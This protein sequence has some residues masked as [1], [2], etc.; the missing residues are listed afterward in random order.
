[1]AEVA[2][3]IGVFAS[4][5]VDD[6]FILL[7]FF[8]DPQFRS[9]QVVFG[10][11][12][13]IALLYAASVVAALAA[14]VLPAAYIGLLGFVPI[15]IG[16]KKIWHRDANG[17]DDPRSGGP[18]PG[19]RYGN[20]V[21]VAAVTVANGADNLSIYTPMFATRTGYEVA[22]FGAVFAVM[23]GVWLAAA[24]WLTRHRTLGIPI[25]RHAHVLVPFV[26]IAL[27]GLILWEAG[28]LTLLLRAFR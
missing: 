1:M 10:Q 18:S 9:R 16:A 2:L 19:S 21:S 5:N 28:T 25:R 7:G 15:F 17:D 26:L 22:A 27:G 11:Y 20:V 13:G 4:T 12:L 6:I 8:A 24:L 23:T 3:A 14:L